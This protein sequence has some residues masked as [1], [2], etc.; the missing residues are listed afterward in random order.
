MTASRSLEEVLAELAA[1]QDELLA[2]A[3]D[4]FAAKAELSNRQDALRSEAREAR[5]AI[6]RD[7]PVEELEVE[8]EPLEAQI[9]GHLESRLSASSGAGGGGRGGT[10]IDPYLMHQMHEK[11]AKSFGLDEKKEQLRRLKN[12]L[13]ELQGE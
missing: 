6:P 5:S 4:D 1:V 10:G 12:R 2:V 13:A 7:V 8:I 9:V 11:M 3:D